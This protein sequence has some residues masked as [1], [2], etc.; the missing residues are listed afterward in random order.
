[1]GALCKRIIDFGRQ[2][3]LREQG[4]DVEIVTY[5]DGSVS[6][7]NRLLLARAQSVQESQ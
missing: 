1:M 7:E 5:I 6:G 4:F 3:W 2:Q